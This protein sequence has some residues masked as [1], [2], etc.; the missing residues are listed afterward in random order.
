MRERAASLSG[1]V[2]TH[3]YDVSV[4]SADQRGCFCCLQSEKNRCF[5]KLYGCVFVCATPL[6]SFAVQTVLVSTIKRD[7]LTAKD[8]DADLV[9]CLFGHDAGQ[10]FCK[11][12]CNFYLGTK[13]PSSPGSAA[14]KAKRFSTDLQNK[15]FTLVW[16]PGRLLS[17]IPVFFFLLLLDCETKHTPI[18]SHRFLSSGLNE[19]FHCQIEMTPLSQRHPSM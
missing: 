1:S 8:S 2:A 13:F 10:L 9:L 16:F 19:Y 15:V 11:A 17:C 7:Y 5:Q 3:H 6:L 18:V 12:L 14:Q 4:K